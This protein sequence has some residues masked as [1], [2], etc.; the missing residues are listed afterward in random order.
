MYILLFSW[1]MY[2][3]Q[4]LLVYWYCTTCHVL[5]LLLVTVPMNTT[6]YTILSTTK[7][8]AP[9]ISCRYC[10]LYPFKTSCSLLQGLG[11]SCTEEKSTNMLIA[12]N[13]VQQIAW[14]YRM[15]INYCS[16]IGLG[17]QPTTRVLTLL[18]DLWNIQAEVPIF[19]QH[20]A[21][22]TLGKKKCRVGNSHI[23]RAST[24]FYKKLDSLLPMK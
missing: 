11:K 22:H 21:G 19:T 15:C 10:C 3:L 12:T 17:Y 5:L 2:D 9:A 7:I 18:E 14:C 4:D 24:H 8:S 13:S 20:L 23:L 16:S 6:L 1:I